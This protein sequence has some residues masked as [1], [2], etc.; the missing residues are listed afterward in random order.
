MLCAVRLRSLA[1]R[2]LTRCATLCALS[3]RLRAGGG[4]ASSSYYYPPPPPPGAG[5]GGEGGKTFLK[6]LLFVLVVVIVLGGVG[7]AKK[8]KL[9]PFAPSRNLKKSDGAL[10]GSWEDDDHGGGG[11]D[12]GGDGGVQ[13]LEDQCGGG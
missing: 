4:A 1:A 10:G 8:N 13:S 12:G 2:R 7:H 3:Q 5:G 9:G 11:V 6:F